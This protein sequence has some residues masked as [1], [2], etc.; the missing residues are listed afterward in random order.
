MHQFLSTFYK[1]LIK[2]EFKLKERLLQVKMI[3]TFQNF[4][5]YLNIKKCNYKEFRENARLQNGKLIV[6]ALKEKKDWRTEDWRKIIRALFLLHSKD[7]NKFA[8][9][10]FEYMFEIDTCIDKYV[11]INAKDNYVMVEL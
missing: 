5:E 8:C 7:A 6:D 3:L 9:M 4:L 2:I 11:I 1:K 10:L